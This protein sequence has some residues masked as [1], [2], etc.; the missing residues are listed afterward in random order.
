M[1]APEPPSEN[2]SVI[3]RWKK[4]KGL[5]HLFSRRWIKLHESYKWKYPNE[6]IKIN[7]LVVLKNDLLPP[8]E[9]S[10]GRVV[11]VCKGTAHNVVR[12]TEIRTQ[13]GIVKRPKVNLCVLPQTTQPTSSLN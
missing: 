4:L 5:H 6:N 12:V 7:D 10:L 8:T 11:S 1:A 9:W 13:N 3:N 2:L